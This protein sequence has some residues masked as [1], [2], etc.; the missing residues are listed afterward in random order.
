MLRGIL[1]LRCPRCRR[2]QLFSEWVLLVSGA[3]FLPLAPFR[4][5]YA[6]AGWIHLDRRMDPHDP[7]DR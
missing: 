5:R 1:T 4:L 3:A 7:K 6:R 2:G